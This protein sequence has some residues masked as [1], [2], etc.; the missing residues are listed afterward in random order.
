MLYGDVPGLVVPSAG[1]GAR[2]VWPKPWRNS[3]LMASITN[4]VGYALVCGTWDV[5]P[6]RHPSQRLVWY[7]CG[8]LE[9]VPQW[10]HAVDC[11]NCGWLMKIE[12]AATQYQSH[13][14][15]FAR[16]QRARPATATFPT[17]RA[18]SGGRAATPAVTCCPF[19][20]CLPPV[21]GG[22]RLYVVGSI[23]AFTSRRR[24]SDSGAHLPLD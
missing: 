21:P 15:G 5:R 9:V 1:V 7:F 16:A 23:P 6:T 24:L 20:I 12:Q 4:A 2:A 17:H 8:G 19:S 18:G 13:F 22:G 10:L 3:D 14:T 11:A